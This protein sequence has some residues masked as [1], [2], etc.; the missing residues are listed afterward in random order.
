MAKIWNPKT[1]KGVCKRAAGRRRYN[2]ERQRK[3][4]NRQL[5][6]MGI[7]VKLNWP[8]YGIGQIL[9]EAL[10]VNAATISR[11]L[12]YIRELRRS[13]I[14]DRADRM[15][16]DFADAIILRLVSARIHPRLGYSWRYQYF[17]GV[18]SLTVR[19]CCP[20]AY[21]FPSHAKKKRASV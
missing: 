19:R 1:F 14:E 8:D 4:D 11:D 20:N 16:D 18:S 21:A 12:K 3:R 17:S 9:A 13:L 15:S 7:L 6:I 2:A 10:S 5:V